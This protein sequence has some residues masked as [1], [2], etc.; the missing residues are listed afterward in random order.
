[1][2]PTGRSWAE[3][4]LAKFHCEVFGTFR[5][6]CS[7]RGGKPVVSRRATLK[8]SAGWSA[9][10]AGRKSGRNAP[11]R[12][13]GK[14]RRGLGGG[15]DRRWNGAFVAFSVCYSRIRCS[16]FYCRNPHPGIHRN[17][18]G[19]RSGSGTPNVGETGIGENLGRSIGRKRD[20]KQEGSRLRRK[21]HFRGPES[22]FY[23]N[24]KI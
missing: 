7:R 20:S 19:V 18:T 24:H 12:S 21:R 16:V 1:M 4:M 5:G 17:K 15:A 23:N 13:I 11:P 22:T 8:A 6:D 10:K 2:L 14:T 3:E 9:L